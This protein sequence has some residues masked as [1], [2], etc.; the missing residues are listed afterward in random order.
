MKAIIDSPRPDGS[1]A[2]SFPSGHTGTAFA[3]AELVR[4]EYGW[5]WGSA[6]YAVATAT[7]VMRMYNNKHWFSDV[8]MGA[9]VG[10]L[11]AN[12]GY[13]LREP[14][15]DLLGIQTS[16]APSID[17]VSGALCAQLTLNF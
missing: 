8:L 4:R 14:C 5:G 10:I 17:T 11:S 12:I 2:K 15:K 9:G 6:A 13:W 1:D 3:G 7:A 16:V